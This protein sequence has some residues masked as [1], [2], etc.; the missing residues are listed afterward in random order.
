MGFKK[1]INMETGITRRKYRDSQWEFLTMKIILN[2]DEV[3]EMISERCRVQK[4]CPDEPHKRYWASFVFTSSR[5]TEVLSE[6]DL[7][8]VEVEIEGAE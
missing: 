4:Y 3:S 2:K 1:R 7:V 5:G 6:A 8:A